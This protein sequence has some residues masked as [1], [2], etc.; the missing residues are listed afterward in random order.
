MGITIGIIHFKGLLDYSTFDFNLVA[1]LAT[2]AVVLIDY[3]QS[4]LLPFSTG[5]GLYADDVVVKTTFWN[6]ET[7]FS[8]LFLILVIAISF[9]LLIKDKFRYLAFGPLFF[10]LAHSLESTVFP[11][12]MYFSHRNY[13]PSI[14]FYF[15]LVSFIYTFFFYIGSSRLLLTLLGIYLSLFA[16]FSYQVSKVWSSKESIVVYAY[17][18]HPQ[19]VRANMSVVEILKRKG[20][21][22]QALDINEML[23]TQRD[24]DTFRP[25]T[26]RVY[27][28][29]WGNLTLAPHE[30]KRFSSA[31]DRYH[32]LEVSNALTN[33]L[34]I[35]RIREC[36]GV[37]LVAIIDLLASWVDEQLEIGNYSTE[38]MWHL[39]YYVIEFLLL[40]EYKERAL[41][42][43]NQYSS[44]GS[45]AAREYIKNRIENPR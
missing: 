9:Y 28:H 44:L 30:Y 41:E 43:L 26:Q 13:L 6:V 2:Q 25:V 5:T 10:L 27:L 15:F 31:I 45:H 4:L 21:M 24:A 1:R 20:K 23:I 38:Q 35:Y 11:L 12:E 8:C 32:A 7:V 18:H 17:Y 16:V 3:I 34:D 42:R 19:S 14:G 29:C 33:L 40:V 22:E 39:E 37:D 36:V